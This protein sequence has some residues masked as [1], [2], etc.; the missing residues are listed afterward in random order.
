MI[1]KGLSRLGTYFLYIVSLLPFRALYLL[2][3][4]LFVIIY[5]IVGYRRKVVQ[6]NLRNSFPEKT[7]HERRV[8]ERKFFLHLT[9]LIVES[10]KM[11]TVTQKQL[12]KRYTSPNSADA[13]K[14]LDQGRGVLIAIGHYGNWEMA[15]LRTSFETDYPLYV[16]YKP[17]TNQVFDKFFFDMRSRFGAKLIAMRNVLRTMVKVKNT[18][19]ISVFVADQTPVRS[20]SNYYTEFLNQQTAFFLGIEKMAKLT[21]SVVFFCDI[22]RQKRGYCRFD[23]IEVAEHPNETADYEITEKYV[24][25]LENTIRRNP[26]Y[27]LWSHRRW[28]FK[29]E[30]KQ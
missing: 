26:P 25:L 27:W 22:H 13:V 11:L 2:S 23:F 5:Y 21:N 7:D 3:D 24:R 9:D 16:V 6:E 29:P 20:E 12:L 28:K 15:N 17:L 14:Y 19:V 1:N 18:P 4:F 8:I 30:D 10:I